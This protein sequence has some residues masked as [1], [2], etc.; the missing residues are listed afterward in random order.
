M[1]VFPRQYHSIAPHSFHHLPRTLHNLSALKA[2][3]HRPSSPCPT[4][5]SSPCTVQPDYTQPPET[6]PTVRPFVRRCYCCCIAVDATVKFE[7]KA[8]KR[9]LVAP[10]Q[11]YSAAIFKG[12]V[13]GSQNPH[14]GNPWPTLCNATHWSAN[15]RL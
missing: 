15:L 2:L 3:S 7:Q 9:W 6:C 4:I 11:T 1:F 8:S 14:I 13:Y 10:K 12:R 5:Q